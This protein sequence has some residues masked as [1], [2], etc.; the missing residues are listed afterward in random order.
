VATHG[1]GQAGDVEKSA[2]SSAREALLDATER[3]LIRSGPAGVTTRSLAES[4]GVNNGLV[5]YYFGSM[6]NL[7]VCVLERFTERLIRRQRAMYAGDGPFLD[8]WRQAMRYLED[9]RPYQKIWLELSA[10]SWNRPDL[11][12]RVAGVGEEWRTVLAEAFQQARTEHRID[13]P[14]DALVALVYSFNVGM[15]VDR[16]SGVTQGHEE[17]L[18]WIDRFLEESRS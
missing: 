17:L 13:M 15:M 11:A 5:H 18:G 2:R 8:K 9:D 3:L 7:L 16:L 1:S 10:L 12:R 4:A 14:L 6:D